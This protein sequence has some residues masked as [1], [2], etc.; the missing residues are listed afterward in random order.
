MAI[1]LTRMRQA[2]LRRLKDLPERYYAASEA[3]SGCP[4]AE[5]DRL[6]HKFFWTE[7]RAA[8]DQ[9]VRGRSCI[10]FGVQFCWWDDKLE[11]V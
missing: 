10:A 5:L 3:L 4:R 7:F 9:L 1:S 11:R 6:I 8:W 2:L